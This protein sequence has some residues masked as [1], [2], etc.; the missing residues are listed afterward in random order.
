MQEKRSWA[1]SPGC[2][3]ELGHGAVH[4]GIVW[5]CFF[6][7]LAF[8]N[9]K[10][11]LI[12]SSFLLRLTHENLFLGHLIQ[13]V[14]WCWD[15][16]GW[17]RLSLLGYKAC[18]PPLLHFPHVWLPKRGRFVQPPKA[19]PWESTE[20]VTRGNS[21]LQTELVLQCM[22]THPCPMR[23]IIKWESYSSQPKAISYKTGKRA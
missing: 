2:A 12:L 17:K 22:K 6:F 3:R 9:K 14:T 20:L 5:R 4:W 18:P 11:T 15:A 8:A 7:S 16:G 21:G 10:K 19:H 1:T 23:T 13:G